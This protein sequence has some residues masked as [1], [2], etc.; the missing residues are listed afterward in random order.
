MI[1]SK[2]IVPGD[3][4]ILSEGDEVGADARLLWVSSLR[5]AESSLT[6]E[7][8]PVDKNPDILPADIAL[9]DR[10]NMVYKGTAVTQ[11]SG[12]AVVTSTGMHT[13]M[14]SI[15]QMLTRS[16]SETTPLQEE[17]DQLGKY[18]GIGVIVIALIIMAT[19]FF[20]RPDRDID[21]FI[22]VLIMGVS[23]AGCRCS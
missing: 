6:V 5:V 21:T 7:S 4:L 20:M 19:V 22:E 17:I 12:V 2:D 23:L 15:A 14:G 1:E 3:I 18:L 9:G 11:G 8:L 13:E 16:D 10:V